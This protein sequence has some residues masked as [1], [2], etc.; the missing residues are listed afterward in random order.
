MTSRDD[1]SGSEDDDSAED[2]AGRAT[3]EAEMSGEDPAAGG[4]AGG[5]RLSGEGTAERAVTGL[6]PLSAASEA[7]GLRNSVLGYIDHLTDEERKVTGG[8]MGFVGLVLLLTA[9]GVL[10]V[11][12]VLYL[13]ALAGMYVLLATGL[14]I[15]WGYTGLINFSVAAFFGVGAYGAVLLSS[16]DSPLTG[17][18]PPVLE[19]P[20]VGQV[21]LVGLNAPVV[22]IVVGMLVGGVLALLIAIPTLSLQEDYLAIASL[23]LAEVVR[24]LIKNQQNWTGGSRGVLGMPEFFETWPVVGS[25]LDVLPPTALDA[26]T[27]L[28]FTLIVWLF[29]RRIHQSPW[30]RV[31]R[32]IRS[33]ADLAEALGKNTYQLRMQSFILGSVIMALGGVFFVHLNNSMF[34]ENL[35]PIRTFYVWIAVILGGSGSDRGAILGGIVIVTIVE[36]SRFLGSGLTVDLGALVLSFTLPIDPGA[37]RLFLVGIIIIG[38]MRYRPEGILPPQR[39]LIWPGVTGEARDE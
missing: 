1:S 16:G 14:N 6:P 33:D 24:I 36:G 35:R 27:V 28:T 13:A 11:S 34:P 12:Y 3:G 39:E 7:R 17:G 10:S 21:T 5:V 23:G 18:A 19:L 26:V 15:Q 37:M 22:G 2:L 20:A 9:L 32:L 30:G 29:V 25:V 4:G 8:V 38:V 31:Q